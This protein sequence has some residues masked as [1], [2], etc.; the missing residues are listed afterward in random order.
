MGGSLQLP[1]TFRD[2]FD[3]LRV[4]HYTRTAT[5]GLLT[6]TGGDDWRKCSE[7]TLRSALLARERQRVVVWP[8]DA[9]TWSLIPLP[10]ARGRCDVVLRLRS[11]PGGATVVSYS[12][13]YRVQA[14]SGCVSGRF[15]NDTLLRGINSTS[16]LLDPTIAS[17]ISDVTSPDVVTPSSPVNQSSSSSSNILPILCPPLGYRNS[18][19]CGGDGRYSLFL[20]E[21]DDDEWLNFDPCRSTTY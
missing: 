2:H 13:R 18:D 19:I 16:V 5:I 4:D 1:A 3:S 20:V 17:S 15:V 8:C 11:P 7:L 10:A 21:E 14:T 9:V 6:T 12:L